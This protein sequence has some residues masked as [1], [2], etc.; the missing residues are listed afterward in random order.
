[1]GVLVLI[2]RVFLM[3]HIFGMLSYFLTLNLC[4]L[5]GGDAQLIT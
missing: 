3:G 5:S 2:D 1:M 4:N